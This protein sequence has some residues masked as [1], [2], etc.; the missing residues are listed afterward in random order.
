MLIPCA[1]R[2]GADVVGTGEVFERS[3]DVSEVR[4]HLVALL[5]EFG[6]CADDEG[7]VAL[8]EF[9]APRNAAKAMGDRFM[10]ALVDESV[11]ADGTERVRIRAV[12]D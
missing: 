11:L 9:D 4:S 6:A 3:V 10:R 5:D 7:L 8:R 12:G 2:C 1:L